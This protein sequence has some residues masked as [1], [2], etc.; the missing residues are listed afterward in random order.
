M[1]ARH[2]TEIRDSLLVLEK[3]LYTASASN[4]Q[5]QALRRSSFHNAGASPYKLSTLEVSRIAGAQSQ[6]IL[7]LPE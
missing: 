7:K 4:I 1:S 3:V 5:M 2:D 6:F